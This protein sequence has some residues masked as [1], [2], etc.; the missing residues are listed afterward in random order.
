[1]MQARDGQN[2]K[3]K[4]L[5]LCRYSNCNAEPNV[6]SHQRILPRGLRY[7]EAFRSVRDSIGV[8]LLSSVAEIT[9][10][11]AKVLIRPEVECIE[12]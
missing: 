1:M 5:S 12:F 4:I 2:Q 11:R 8:C 7:L 6:A 9:S 3:G 10:W